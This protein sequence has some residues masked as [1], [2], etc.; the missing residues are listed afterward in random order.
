MEIYLDDP[1]HTGDL[2]AFLQR[3]RCVIERLEDGG[4]LVRIPDSPLPDAERLELTLY[5]QTW[6]AV[7][8]GAQGPDRL[9]EPASNRVDSRLEPV[10]RAELPEDVGDMALRG[11]GADEELGRDLGVVPAA[12]DQAEHL[13]LAR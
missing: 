1:R 5:L 3:A 7:H 12:C 8:P 13:E 4:L 11:A 9:D 2:V 10:L 6:C